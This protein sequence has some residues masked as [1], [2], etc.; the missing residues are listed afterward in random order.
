MII[1]CELS[2]LFS[3]LTNVWVSSDNVILVTGLWYTFILQSY[4]VIISLAG[5]WRLNY[6]DV[7]L[8]R[9][10]S[11]KKEDGCVSFHVCIRNRL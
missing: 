8:V 11:M 1:E 5:L 6:L 7:W 4:M 10:K 3:R 9:G 2:E